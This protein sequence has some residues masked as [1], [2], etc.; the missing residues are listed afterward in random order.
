MPHQF[1]KEKKMKECCICKKEIN[2]EKEICDEC[3]EKELKKR[4]KKIKF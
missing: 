4:K 3:K 1:I 2:E